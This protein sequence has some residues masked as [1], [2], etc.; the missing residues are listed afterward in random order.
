MIET[1]RPTMSMVMDLLPGM[2]ES[3]IFN[4]CAIGE[5]E[6]DEFIALIVVKVDGS[7]IYYGFLR[8]LSNKYSRYTT[9]LILDEA[10]EKFL[11]CP[12]AFLDAI[13]WTSVKEGHRYA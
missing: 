7:D 5:S 8:D 2:Q 12:D 6:D 11:F 1:I 10:S 13:S 3:W 4:D 9:R